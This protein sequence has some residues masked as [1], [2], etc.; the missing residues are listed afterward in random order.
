MNWELKWS[1]YYISYPNNEKQPINALSALIM[2]LWIHFNSP[3]QLLEQKLMILNYISSFF[4]HSTYNPF[5]IFLDNE[6]MSSAVLVYTFNNINKFFSHSLLSAYL[7]MYGLKID[8]D[9]RFG[10]ITSLPIFIQMANNKIRYRDIKTLI[11][12]CFCHYLDKKY[13]NTPIKY[14]YLHSLWHI[15]AGISFNN[16]LNYNN[17]NKETDDVCYFNPIQ[18]METI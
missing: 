2:A 1:E 11:I 5:F 17:V 18:S 12:G 10:I 9:I 8:F 15:L 3:S 16:I 13:K 7:I 14:I 6:T 4:A